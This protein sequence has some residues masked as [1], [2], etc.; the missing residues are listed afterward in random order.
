MVFN[1]DQYKIR[2]R[3]SP[4]WL[5]QAL[6]P[7]SFLMELGAGARMPLIQLID[8]TLEGPESARTITPCP[9]CGKL[10]DARTWSP[11]FDTHVKNWFG[12]YCSNCGNVIPCMISISSMLVLAVTFPLWI[13]FKKPLKEHWLRAQPARFRDLEKQYRK[14]PY[15][16]RWWL[17][18]SLWS[19]GFFSVVFGLLLPLIQG[20]P[21]S[22]S[23]VIIGLLIGAA[24]GFSM[25]PGRRTK[26]G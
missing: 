4:L 15:G 20:H 21:F 16:E 25:N 23:R 19:G 7:F 13:W 1:P 10:H 17:S 14:D 2:T 12:L 6:N 22:W 9:H 26:Q 8:K 5:F 24:I 11:L 3:K 18:N